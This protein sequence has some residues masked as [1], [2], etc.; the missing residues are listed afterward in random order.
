MLTEGRIH[1]II[2]EEI[3]KNDEKK[4]KKIVSSCVEELFRSL[5][6]KRVTWKHD[7]ENS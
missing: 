7:I 3:T 4:I 6:T 2:S 5:W 1:Q